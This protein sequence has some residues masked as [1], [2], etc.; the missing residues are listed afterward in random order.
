[1]KKLLLACIVYTA[2]LTDQACLSALDALSEEVTLLRLAPGNDLAT[3]GVLQLQ[4]VGHFGD[5]VD[6]RAHD[7]GSSSLGDGREEV[8]RRLEQVHHVREPESLK[9]ITQE[10][11]CEKRETVFDGLDVVRI[12]ALRREVPTCGS[13]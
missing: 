13:I 2:I 3:E 12:Y 11:A 8:R 1:M 9:K 4:R 6:D 5:D 10:I 7:L